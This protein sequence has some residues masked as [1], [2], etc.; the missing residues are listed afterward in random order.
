MFNE[1]RSFPTHNR[2]HHFGSKTQ[3]MPKRT[4]FPGRYQYQTSDTKWY[5]DTGTED[6]SNVVPTHLIARSLYR[7]NSSSLTIPHRVL[8]A[9]PW[10]RDQYISVL[11]INS[12]RIRFTEP[13][14]LGAFTM[15]NLWFS[16]I[17]KQIYS[18][19]L[20]MH[21]HNAW[22]PFKITV[23]LAPKHNMTV[24]FAHVVCDLLSLGNISVSEVCQS[25]LA[26]PFGWNTF[27]TVSCSSSCRCVYNLYPT[28]V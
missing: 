2:G 18:H 9:L 4:A 11:P 20:A 21:N 10:I 15:I 27:G 26:P 8:H 7:I 17:Q 16:L 1:T 14:Q 25:N 6:T 12:E 28:Y 13:D 3:H 22:G 19:H 24:Q 23:V 5:I